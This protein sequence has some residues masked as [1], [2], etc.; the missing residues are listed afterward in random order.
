MKNINITSNTLSIQSG[1]G[2]ASSEIVKITSDGT[3][4]VSGNNSY[5]TNNTGMG[6]INFWRWHNKM[7]EIDRKIN[8]IRE[9]IELCVDDNG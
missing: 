1:F 4:F 8:R 3:V 7:D 9:F 6:T 5:I 2:I